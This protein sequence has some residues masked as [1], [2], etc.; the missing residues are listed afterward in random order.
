MFTE[1][2]EKGNQPFDKY[3]RITFWLRDLQYDSKDIN[4][5]SIRFVLVLIKLL[6]LLFYVI[7]VLVVY[8]YPCVFGFV[9]IIY[10]LF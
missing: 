3:N 8:P 5:R 4:D 2:V 9:V 1:Y 6:I 10:R 7:M